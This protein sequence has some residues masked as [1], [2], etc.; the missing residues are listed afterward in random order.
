MAA[1]PIIAK[2]EYLIVK[3]LPSSPVAACGGT[4]TRF[5]LPRPST[6]CPCTAAH[7]KFVLLIL[8]SRL[9]F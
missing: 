4:G 2:I 3:F 6:L 8:C 1:V 7:L 9:A 5:F